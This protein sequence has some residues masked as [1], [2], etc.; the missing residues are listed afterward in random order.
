ML[1]CS[2]LV[3][4]NLDYQQLSFGLFLF[5]LEDLLVQQMRGKRENL[6]LSSVLDI[7]VVICFCS[8][9]VPNW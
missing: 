7:Y 8:D 1:L 2:M 4:R 5:I 3:F 9:S 6:Y